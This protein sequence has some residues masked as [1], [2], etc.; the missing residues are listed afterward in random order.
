VKILIADDEP[1]AR[2]RLRRLLEELARADWVIEEATDGQEALKTAIC[3]QPDVMLLDIHMPL[4]SGLQCARELSRLPQA[5]AMVFVTA[6]DDY[7]LEAFEVCACDYLLKPVRLERLAGALERARRFSA[8][9]WKKLSAELPEAPVSRQ[10]LCSIEHG[11]V[12][13]LAIEDILYFLADRKSTLARTATGRAHVDESLKSLEAEFGGR[14]LRVHRN[15]LVAPVY[16]D[17]LDRLAS[18]GVALKLK[19][20][21]ERIEVSRR[22]LPRLR[23]DLGVTG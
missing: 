8:K 11:N 9:A 22:L 16:I 21:P 18:G 4:M 20:I 19:G 23:Q 1:L 7:A 2:A 14:F 3:L 17:R 13:F 6:Y 12:C 5:P 15:A 10:H